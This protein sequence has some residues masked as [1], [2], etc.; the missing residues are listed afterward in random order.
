MNDIVFIAD[1]LN[2]ENFGDAFAIFAF[3]DH[4]TF[5]YAIVLQSFPHLHIEFDFV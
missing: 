4:F 3:V 1:A 2:T 5:P